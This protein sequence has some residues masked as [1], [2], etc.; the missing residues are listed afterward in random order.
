LIILAV[1]LFL[2][3]IKVQSFG[4]LTVGGLISMVLGSVILF[5]NQEIYEQV[6]FG[7]ILPVTLFFAAVF[8]ILL[9]MVVRT[10]RQGALSGAQSLIG[11]KAEV[12]AWSVRKVQER[13]SATGNTGM[14]GDRVNSSR[15]TRWRYRLFMILSS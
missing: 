10:Q 8:V 7:I 1:I 12:Y 15:E 9:Y 2:A 14:P 3:E 5:R 4:M 13:F 11:Q 6:S